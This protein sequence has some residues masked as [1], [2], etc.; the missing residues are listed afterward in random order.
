MEYLLIFLEFILRSN[1]LAVVYLKLVG[2]LEE[3]QLS[4]GLKNVG[5]T[6]R[7]VAF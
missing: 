1:L 7:F 2:I 5:L 6:G 4:R 3:E